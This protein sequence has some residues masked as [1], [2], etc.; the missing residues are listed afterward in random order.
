MYRAGSMAIGVPMKD[1]V[2]QTSNMSAAEVEGLRFKS[3]QRL[4]V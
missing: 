1:R 4:E 2:G 3:Q